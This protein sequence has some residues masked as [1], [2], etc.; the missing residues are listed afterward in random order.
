MDAFVVLM[1][2]TMVREKT[3]AGKKSAGAGQKLLRTTEE[4]LSPVVGNFSFALMLSCI[5]IV[6]ILGVLVLFIL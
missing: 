5:G 6:V 4:A 3:A 2:R 1:R